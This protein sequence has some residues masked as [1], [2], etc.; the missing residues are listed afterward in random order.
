MDIDDLELEGGD[1]VPPGLLEYR[2]ST[3]LPAEPLLGLPVRRVIPMDV[4]S[5]VDYASS[6]ATL[7]AGWIAD[8]GE[9]RAAAVALGSSG[10]G[11]SLLTDYKLS[12]AKVIPIEVHEAIDYVWGAATVAAPFVFGYWKRD[13][14]AASL[15][16]CAGLGTI[17]VS[18]FTDYRAARG[19]TWGRVGQHRPIEGEP[20]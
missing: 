14:V 4:H 13:P 12:A 8:S 16:V 9:A 20:Y 3:G 6:L 18:M 19:V 11:V 2:F 15:H 5:L 17:L 1:L 7:V 10:L